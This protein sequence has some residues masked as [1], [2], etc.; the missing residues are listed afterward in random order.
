MS[1]GGDRAYGRSGDSPTFQSHHRIGIEALSYT[2]DT[3]QISVVVKRTNTFAVRP[4]SDA[5]ERL[6]R[7][8]LDAPASLWTELNYERQQNYFECGRRGGRNCPRRGKSVWDTDD[9]RRRYVDVTGSPTA[10]QLIRKNGAVWELFFSLMATY[11]DPEDDKVTQRPSPPG[12]W[13]NEDDGREVRTC[14]R[15]D[16]YTL[17]TGERSRLDIPVGGHLKEEFGLDPRESDCGSKSSATR[18]GRASWTDSKSRTT[19]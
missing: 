6:F 4:L 10:Q 11:E 8:L 12:Y 19:R 13:G 14:I 16:M 18:G 2:L 9:Y 7:R 3:A 1:A 15:N 17:E 5:D